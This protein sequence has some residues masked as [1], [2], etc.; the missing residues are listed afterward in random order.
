M[1][2]SSALTLSSREFVSPAF[3]LL[4][5]LGF[6][7]IFLRYSIPPEYMKAGSLT[8]SLAL[9]A[10]HGLQVWFFLSSYLIARHFLSDLAI[11]GRIDLKA[12]YYRRVL[13]FLPAYLVILLLAVTSSSESQVTAGSLTAYT[14][15]CANWYYYFLGKVRLVI[16]PLWPMSLGAQF[17]LIWPW[18][19]TSLEEEPVARSAYFLLAA[20]TL[21]TLFLGTMPRHELH[22]ATST[23]SQGQF[24]AL[25]ALAAVRLHTSSSVIKDIFRVPLTMLS[26]A[27]LYEGH[28]SIAAARGGLTFVLS[29]ILLGVAVSGLF[30]SFYGW[31]VPA[32]LRPLV[33]LGRMTYSLF[34]IFPLSNRLI[35]LVTRS[36]TAIPTYAVLLASFCLTVVLASVFHMFLLTYL[37]RRGHNY[38]R[39]RARL[40]RMALEQESGL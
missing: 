3:D 36:R 28:A 8:R 26:L 1:K 34:L 22:A 19:I 25:G 5:L 7:G 15:L 33:L 2:P 27:L 39:S 20:S 12:F 29:Y 31:R 17:Y 21:S 10:G 4:R 13:R 35:V 16:E 37:N 9:S 40:S 32:V 24:F 23:F 6:V 38:T 14:F 11:L 18:L 30:L